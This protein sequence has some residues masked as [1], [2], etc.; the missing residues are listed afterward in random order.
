MIERIQLLRNIGQFDNVSPPPQSALTPFSLVYGENGRGKTTLAAILRSLA[1]NNPGLLTDRHRLGAQYPPHVVIGHAGGQCV[2]QN[3]AWTQP[4]PQVAIFDDAFVSANVCSGIELQTSHRQNLH[5]LILG[6]QGVA[7]NDMLQGHVIRVE[8][9]NTRLRELA[10]AIPAN[11]R[12][13]YKVDIYC[14]LEQDPAVDAKIQDAERRLAA[15]RSADAIRQ[16]P[17]FQEFGLPNFDL[18]A[19]DS[20]LDRSLAELEAAAAGRVRAHLAR[21]G[22]GGEAWVSDGMTRIE[23]VS[24]GHD[25]KICPFC[26]QDLGDSELID[27]Y[28]A[29]FSQAYE[30]LKL[31]IRQTG[32]AIRDTHAGDIPSA[33]E[34]DI[35]TAV[36]AHEFWNDF[37][38]LPEI[39][40]DTAAIARQW[41]TAREGVLEQ[42]RAKAAAP[43]D[44]M[45]L[46]PEVRQ[47]VMDY[48]ARIAEVAALSQR[49]GAVNARLHV[50]KEQAQ[51]DD[52]AALTDD[53]TKLKAQ[54]ARF[55][56]AV[57]PHCDAYMAEKTAKAATEALR[58]QARAALDQ[59]RE[60][61]FPAYE[62]AINE[63]LRR[64]AAS[65]RLGEV[66]SVNN[67]SGSSASYCVVINQQ[68]V[69][70]TADEGPSFRNTLSAGDRNTLALAFFFASLDQDPDLANKIVVIDDPMTSL[71][72][73]RTLR[74]REEI[75]ALFARVRQVIVLSHSKPF[76]C[77]LWEQSDRNVS[78][79]LRI[80]RAAVGSEITIWDVRNDSISEHDKR[81]E[82]VRGYLL[83]ADPD[84]ERQVAAALRPIL[85]AFMRVAYPEHFPPGTLLGPFLGLCDQRL[86]QN[87]EILSAGDIAELRALLGYA[88]L[89]H[90]DTNPAWQTAAINDAEL[91]DFAERALLFAS[92]R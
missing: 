28:R 77:N 71:D 40:V 5:E 53:L 4:R 91:T 89:F 48:R 54:K 80:N 32:V 11:A 61:I 81:H 70:L 84:K 83:A 25:A 6:G 17:G 69:N 44:R 41:N 19:I 65:F 24:K 22:R 62:T 92:R 82:L 18:D 33:F 12:G 8:E 74:T 46:S 9:H 68:D 64:F 55:D 76:L 13:P 78:T 37:A 90:H 39:E 51:A 38:E 29:Y 75:M 60:Q 57:V 42:L 72:E 73:H 3:G 67:R 79:A 58:T 86:G 63:Y 49:L 10:D 45:T 1:T 2:F 23:P 85:E 14:S 7:L 88:N 34:R 31:A 27:H 66:Q 56:P 30:D 50:V 15:A 35:R 87:N 47:A 52:L 36:Q 26:A 59:Y 43:L 21:L 20:I 16:R